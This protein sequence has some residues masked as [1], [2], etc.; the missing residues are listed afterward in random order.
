MDDFVPA[1]LDASHA[2]P[3][4]LRSSFRSDDA[5]RFAVYRNNVASSLIKALGEIFPA[6]RRIAGDRFF[7]AMAH[8]FIVAHPPGSPL[9]F[10]YGGD[11]PGFVAT[12]EPA[13]K[14]PYLPDLARLEKAWLDAW[15]AA[16]IAP[17]DG[18]NLASIHVAPLPLARFVPH[19]AA[20]IVA[21]RYAIDDLFRA[22]RGKSAAQRID[23]SIA[24]TVL[25]TRPDFAVTATPLGKDQAIFMLALLDGQPLEAA[26]DAALACNQEFDLGAGL[27]L[28]LRSGAFQGMAE[29]DR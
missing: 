22:N 25:V 17:L 3:P 9:L 12:F 27:A 6:S 14:M 7:D 13:G 18:D 29:L 21:S 2:P 4:G 16:D 1:L 26:A 15:H 28:V 19:P 23:A 24:Q 5:G 8:A 10:R 11:F 20:R